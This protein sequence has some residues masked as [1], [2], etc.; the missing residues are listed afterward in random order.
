LY[1]CGNN[2]LT[3][4]VVV[5][6]LSGKTAVT[7]RRIVCVTTDCFFM[8]DVVS[9]SQHCCQNEVTRPDGQQVFQVSDFF[10]LNLKTKKRVGGIPTLLNFTV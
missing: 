4:G 6:Q 5:T 3:E 1:F 8:S 9:N 7:V 2:I 10:F